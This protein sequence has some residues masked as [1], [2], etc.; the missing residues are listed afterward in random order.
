MPRSVG[1]LLVNRGG[2]AV[3]GSK[4]RSDYSLIFNGDRETSCDFVTQFA[5]KLGH[6]EGRTKNP[7]LHQS[8]AFAEEPFEGHEAHEEHQEP[9]VVPQSGAS[10]AGEDDLGWVVEEFLQVV[11]EFFGP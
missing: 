4:N 2:A 3:R 1:R 8:A 5:S 9:P 10:D 11:V 7:Y 6:S